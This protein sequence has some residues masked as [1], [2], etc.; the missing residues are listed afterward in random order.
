MNTTFENG[1]TVVDASWLNDVNDT[2]YGVLGDGTNPPTS[3]AAIRVNIGA[4]AASPNL[5]EYAAVNPTTAGLALLDDVDAAAQRTT[6]GLGSDAT[7]TN[8][9][10]LTNTTTARSNLG[11][12]QT[13]VSGTNIKTINGTSL[14]GSGDVSISTTVSDG[15]KGDIIVSSGGTVWTLDPSVVPH[16]LTS[17]TAINTTSRTAH[18]F[19]GI[20]TGVKRISINFD[21]VS[22]N[23][24]SNLFMQIGDS[25]GIEITGYKASGIYGTTVTGSTSGFTITAFRDS[26]SE[27]YS[28]SIV[29]SIIDP[30]TFKWAESGVLATEGTRTHISAGA[31]SLSAVLDRIR[32]TTVNGTDTFDSGTINIL[33]E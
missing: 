1:I 30:S 11:A 18:D 19:T 13:L 21:G 22:T 26:A 31:K 33:Y 2:V 6:L 27:T 23:G 3:A 20:P 16:P 29:L 28:G 5:D 4:Q 15:D 12:Q 32:I 17:G 10:S 25:G 14:L 9:S 24:T 8:L 7:G